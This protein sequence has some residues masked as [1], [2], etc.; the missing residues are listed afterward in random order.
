MRRTRRILAA[1]LL[2]AVLAFPGAGGAWKQT[3]SQSG[4]PLSWPGSCFHWSLNGDGYSRLP[5]ETLRTVARASFATWEAPECSYFRFVE[6]APTGVSEQ[7]FH[8]DARNANALIWREGPG[9]WPYGQAVIALTSVHYDV[10]TGEILDVDVEFNGEDFGFTDLDG[11]EPG[12]PA[13]DLRSTMTHELGHCLGLDHTDVADAT[14]FAAGEAGATWKRTLHPDD[15]EG[16]CAIYPV[17]EDPDFCEEPW[18]GFD[19]DGSAGPCET[20]TSDAGCGC[21]A[22]GA[23]GGSRGFGARLLGLLS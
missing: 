13:Y 8:L 4:R 11:P 7:A 15:I 6:T 16:L 21:A 5:F 20:G 17:A 23:R 22:P 18:C 10:L 9:S 12:N 3:A 1:L 19:E 14:M 2:A